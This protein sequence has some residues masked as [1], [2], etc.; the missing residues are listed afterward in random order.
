MELKEIESAI[1]GVLFAAGE[2]VGVDI[3]QTE[4]GLRIAGRPD[5]GYP[6]GEAKSWNDHR[7][8]M[9]MAVFALKTQ[10]GVSLEGAG[11]VAK[12][13]PSFWDDL[14]MIGGVLHE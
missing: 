12:S 2:P 14:T 10:R 5:G 6:G 4:D 9:A 1:E 8:A 13:W 3:E 11:S 7:I